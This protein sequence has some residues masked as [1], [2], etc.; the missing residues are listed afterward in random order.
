MELEPEEPPL[1]RHGCPWL[2]ERYVGSAPGVSLETRVM[3]CILVGT[4]GGLRR[5]CPSC[6]GPP[7]VGTY[8]GDVIKLSPLQTY[9]DPF[10]GEYQ[11]REAGG[12]VAH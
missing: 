6:F 9:I 2:G 11:V 12:H 3:L 4:V 5:L 8:G 1:W 10:S 7:T